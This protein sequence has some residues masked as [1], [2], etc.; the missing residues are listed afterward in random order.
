MGASAL[1]DGLEYIRLMEATGGHLTCFF[2]VHET[3]AACAAVFSEV[4]SVDEIAD[5]KKSNGHF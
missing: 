1:R 5:P 3:A 2:Y 4:P